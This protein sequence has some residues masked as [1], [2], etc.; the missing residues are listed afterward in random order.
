MVSERDL[1][2]NSLLLDSR[3]NRDEEQIYPVHWLLDNLY[4]REAWYRHLLQQKEQNQ[5]NMQQDIQKYQL[6]LKKWKTFHQNIQ[7]Q[8][9]DYESQLKESQQKLDSI[10]QEK[11]ELGQKIDLFHTEMKIRDQKMEVLEQEIFTRQHHEQELEQK[12]NVLDKLNQELDQQKKATT[13]ELDTI[14]IELQTEHEDKIQWK[15]ALMSKEKE[16][17]AKE[18]IYQEQWAGIESAMK[19][20]LLAKETSFEQTLILKDQQLTES[21]KQITC[22]H[23]ELKQKNLQIQELQEHL[24]DCINELS[25]MHQIIS[26]KTW[27]M[28]RTKRK[29]MEQKDEIITW[30]K[31]KETEYKQ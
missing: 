12:L 8:E 16:W 31:R 26:A 4:R 27:I 20:E 11:S 9:Q 10:L 13:E 14:K 2:S 23:K 15:Q 30:Y 25:G 18:Q 19:Q 1:I 24:D 7:S 5:R 21:H 28:G 17:E 29:L 22:A 6:I 3:V